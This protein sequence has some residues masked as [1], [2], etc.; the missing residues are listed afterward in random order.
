MFVLP[1]IPLHNLAIHEIAVGILEA[2]MKVLLD[3]HQGLGTHGLGLLPNE[4]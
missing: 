4:L 1:H 2:G 3:G